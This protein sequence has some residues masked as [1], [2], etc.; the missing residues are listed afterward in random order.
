MIS[1]EICL[2]VRRVFIIFWYF[3]VLRVGIASFVNITWQSL[4]GELVRLEFLILFYGVKQVVRP[5]NAATL[6]SPVSLPYAV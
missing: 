4:K 1:S 5:R 6:A 2:Q 3:S